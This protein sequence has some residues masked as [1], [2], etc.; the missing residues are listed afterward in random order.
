MTCNFTQRRPPSL[1]CRA[2]LR[3]IILIVVPWREIKWR[4]VHRTMYYTS[5]RKLQATRDCAKSL[6]A[7]VRD[8]YSCF[9][10]RAL[11]AN[12]ARRMH[13]KIQDQWFSTHADLRS[14]QINQT[15]ITRLTKSLLIS[16]LFNTK[17]VIF[18]ITFYVIDILHYT[19]IVFIDFY[20]ILE[21]NKIQ[22]RFS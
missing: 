10:E 15:R 1:I 8:T 11:Q 12:S 3:P 19:Y 17:K 2:V 9:I 22:A 14:V 20:F 13:M 6:H 21:N 16:A 4:R 18:L 5:S 7:F